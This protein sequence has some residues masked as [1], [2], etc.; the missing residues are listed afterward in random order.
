MDEEV[1]HNLVTLAIEALDHPIVARQCSLLKKKEQ[2]IFWMAY[3]C[4]IVWGL[5]TSLHGLLSRN[6]VRESV[7]AVREYFAT[8]PWYA[9]A[10]FSLM[11]HQM[12]IVMPGKF[13]PNLYS[14]PSS[15]T[16]DIQKAVQAAGYT[17]DITYDPEFVHHVAQALKHFAN[18]ATSAISENNG[19]QSHSEKEMP[20]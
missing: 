5:S 3:G 1:I 10:P 12:Q 18:S 17:W 4:Y 14:D 13:T 6:E 15:L 8:Y 2:P 19:S 16:A 7:R 11:L 20:S 9:S